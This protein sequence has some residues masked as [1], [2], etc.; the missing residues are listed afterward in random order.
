MAQPKEAGMRKSRRWILLIVSLAGLL[1]MAAPAAAGG[2]GGGGPCSGFGSGT[3][4]VLR[5]NCFD[6]VAFSVQ[7]GTDLVVTNDGGQSHSY[8]AVDGSFNTG[9]LKPGATAHIKVGGAGIVQVYCTIHG[10]ASGEGMAGVLLVGDPALASTASSGISAEAKGAIDQQSA[11]LAAEVADRAAAQAELK[12]ELASIRQQVD[13]LQSSRLSGATLL[14]LLGSVL[15]AGA[16]AAVYYRRR[17]AG[18][19]QH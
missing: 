5:D 2:G 1:L 11:L 18:V 8:T 7:P 19:E 13:T 6:T 4:V 9:L 12:S 14:G 10:T 15:G 16:L 3:K 17:P